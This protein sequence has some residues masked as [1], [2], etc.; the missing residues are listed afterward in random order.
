[1]IENIIIFPQIE[2]YQILKYYK[3]LINGTYE[4]PLKKGIRYD[5]I[6]FKLNVNSL[7]YL[8]ILYL[9]H[10]GIHKI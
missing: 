5:M 4:V 6:V 10:S 9:N 8:K 7:T 2:F 3:R 1:M